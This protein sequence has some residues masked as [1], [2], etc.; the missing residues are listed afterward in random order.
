MNTIT[1]KLTA[2][3]A[4]L[5]MNG[6]IIGAVGYLFEIRSIHSCRCLRLPVRW[7]RMRGSLED[8]LTGYPHFCA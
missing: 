8:R 4:A 2:F 5:L 6:L 1:S 3:A 7:L